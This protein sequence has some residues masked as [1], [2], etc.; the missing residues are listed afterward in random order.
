MPERYATLTEVKAALDA[1]ELPDGATIVL[2]NDHALM[3]DPRL[4]P[5]DV[6][7]PLW[8][9]DNPCAA[10]EQALDALGLK[11]EDA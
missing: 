8:R 7:E 1:G 2:D 5:D 3:W 11:W 9:G 4:D 10:V 6:Q